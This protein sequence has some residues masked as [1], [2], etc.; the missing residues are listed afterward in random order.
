MYKIAGARSI[1]DSRL[2]V[3]ESEFLVR[4]FQFKQ[5]RAVAQ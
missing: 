5:V 3:R 2:V 4:F 1:M